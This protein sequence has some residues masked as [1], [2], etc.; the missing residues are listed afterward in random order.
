MLQSLSRIDS[1]VFTSLV[2]FFVFSFSRKP[3]HPTLLA[4]KSKKSKFST[5]LNEGRRT[6]EKSE[7]ST[8]FLIV[9]QIIFSV[10]AGRKQKADRGETGG[11]VV[12]AA[13]PEIE[14]GAEVARRSYSP[15]LFLSRARLR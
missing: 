13:A 11:K 7:H 6:S 4:G 12:E 8:D 9:G 1:F 2:I 3:L 14:A 10:V 15:T 5:D